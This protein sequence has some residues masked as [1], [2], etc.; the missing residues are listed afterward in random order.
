[1]L[2]EKLDHKDLQETLALKDSLV[3][4]DNLEN[5]DPTVLKDHRDQLEI[6]EKMEK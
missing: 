5:K 2:Q 4:L 1:M 6:K 3:M